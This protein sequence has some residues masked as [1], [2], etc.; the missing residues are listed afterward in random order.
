VATSEADW[1]VKGWF[2]RH[3]LTVLAGLFKSGKSS[4]VGALL[5][6]LGQPG[7]FCGL[8]LIP[9]PVIVVTEEGEAHWARRREALTIGD[10]VSMV[11]RPFRGRPGREDWRRFC[12]Y[13]TGVTR[14]TAAGLVVFDT[15]HGLW[16]VEDENH[17]AMTLDALAELTPIAEAGAALLLVC[18]TSKTVQGEGR[19]LRGSGAIAGF[20]D[21]LLDFTRERP[22]DPLCRRR[23]INAWSRFPDTPV[24]M[25]VEQQAET[26]TYQS[27]VSS[28]QAAA[29]DAAA[30][31]LRA[32]PD[33]PPGLTVPDVKHALLTR[34]DQ[35]GEGTI[36]RRLEGL[37]ASG[38]VIRLGTG[39]PGD[40][41]RYYRWP[42]TSEMRPTSA[43]QTG[44]SV[45]VPPLR[46]ARPY[47]GEASHD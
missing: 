5:A 46:Y 31:L 45:V 6:A 12:A 47:D 40:P 39:R 34:G 22:D 21:I 18:H 38:G 42:G 8:P 37:A 27:A 32:L 7:N 28:A 24:V 33:A 26:G 36:R 44:L 1:I 23:V 14:K 9:A 35:T 4:W 29:H 3:H 20:A 10:H 13:L 25:Y 11:V 16:G 15:L 30:P 19:S 41:S 17:G 43:A 2:A